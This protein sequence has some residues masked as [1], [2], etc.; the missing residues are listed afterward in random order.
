MEKNPGTKK[1]NVLVV[2]SS[3]RQRSLMG[4]RIR[5]PIQEIEKSQLQ[6]SGPWSKLKPPADT[7]DAENN[8]DLFDVTHSAIKLE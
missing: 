3:Y 1:H 8:H 6:S 5:Y 7:T 4:V 2:C